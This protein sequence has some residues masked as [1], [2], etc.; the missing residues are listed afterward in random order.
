MF[1]RLLPLVYDAARD[2]KPVEVIDLCYAYLLDTFVQWQF[3]KT[4]RSNLVEDEKERRFYLDGFLGISEY[5]FWQYHFPGM[6]ALLR[7]IGVHVIP[8][9]VISAFEAV[10]QWNLD[11]CDKAHELL[12]SRKQLSPEEQPIAFEQAFKGVGDIKAEE[13]K[14]YPQR[15]PL[16]S[17]MFSLNSGAFETSGNTSTYLLYEL[18]RRPEWQEKLQEELRG[19]H[20]SLKHVPGKTLGIDDI[21]SAQD[22]DKLPVLHAV[23]FE[24]LRLWPSVPGGQPR[25][26]PR[27]CSL[28]GYD[29]IPAGT[30]VQSYASVLHRTPHVFPDPFEWKPERWLESSPEDLAVMKKW[31]W[32]FG[33]GGRMCLGMHFAYYCGYKLFFGPAFGR[34]VY[35]TNTWASY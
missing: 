5:T 6:T 11:K 13:A 16:A 2:D 1:R 29:G 7:V 31:F 8:K 34:C 22:I 9:S 32:G 3:G 12:A 25:V 14:A 27:S 21:P 4:L 24:T 19:L 35:F 15:L 10:E 18:S 26:V 23:L 28:G 17:D 20:P 30:T 33:S